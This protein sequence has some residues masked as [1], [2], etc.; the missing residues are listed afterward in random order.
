M[1]TRETRLDRG[2]K[3][4]RSMT[5]RLVN[6]LVVARQTLN[7]SQRTLAR[8]AGCSQS[9]VWRLEHLARIDD[10]SVVRLAEA[11]S[12]LGLEL[13]ASLH[14]LGDP[15]RDR[16]HRHCCRVSG[17]GSRRAL[18]SSP[19]HRCPTWAIAAPGISCCESQVS[20]LASRPKRAFDTSNCWFVGLENENGTAA[21]MRFCLLFPRAQ[22]TA[23]CFPSSL[24]D[25]GR[26]S[27]P[28]GASSLEHL[29]SVDH[30]R[31]RACSWSSSPRRSRLRRRH[32]RRR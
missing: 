3:R 18:V 13:S 16:G 30:S 31:D 27:L 2:R 15:I 4:G 22:S 28:R 24:T 14:P 20:S 19:R 25:L 6:E 7:V 26:A 11:A 10:I 8:E 1:A 9:E 29:L 17:T 23:G 12:L 21:F 32:F 5:A